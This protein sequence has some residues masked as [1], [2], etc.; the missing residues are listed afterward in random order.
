MF[1]VCSS[2]LLSRISL[3]FDNVLNNLLDCFT[4]FDTKKRNQIHSQ[5]HIERIDKSL[6]NFLTFLSSIESSPNSY[7]LLSIHD[8]SRKI[9]VI[10]ANISSI[11]IEFIVHDWE[12]A[13]NLHSDEGSNWYSVATNRLRRVSWIT[14]RNL[15]PHIASLSQRF[16]HDLP[17]SP[18]FAS[19]TRHPGNN[20]SAIFQPFWIVSLLNHL[21]LESLSKSLHNN[22][23]TIQSP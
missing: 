7:H 19:P 10:I 12:G 13:E 22:E 1:V 16:S 15:H 8:M 14:K 20:F 21:Q 6:F 5:F 2:W 9:R 17:Q 3:M 11:R 18:L 4:I 23:E